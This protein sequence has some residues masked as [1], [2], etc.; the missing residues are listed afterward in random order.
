MENI[1]PIEADN[2]IK[3]AHNGKDPG[4]D[5]LKAKIYKIYVEQMT[6]CLNNVL[7]RILSGK[8][9]EIFAQGI[10]KSSTRKENLGY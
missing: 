10:V 6:S 5:E 9:A 8:G 1:L 4:S 3:R 2:K 7:N